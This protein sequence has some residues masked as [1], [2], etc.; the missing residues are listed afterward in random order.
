MARG[1]GGPGVLRIPQSARL[2]LLAWACAALIVLIN[3]ALLL[4]LAGLGPS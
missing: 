4:S 2:E 3:S 1:P